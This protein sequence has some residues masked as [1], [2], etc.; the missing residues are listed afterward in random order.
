M[1]RMVTQDPY[2]VER[3]NTLFSNQRS[4]MKIV[5]FKLQIPTLSLHVGAD[6]VQDRSYPNAADYQ[7]IVI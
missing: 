2:L 6:S 5:D 4:R 3:L 7:Q 1:C